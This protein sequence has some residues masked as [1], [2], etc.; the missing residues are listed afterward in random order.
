MFVCGNKEGRKRGPRI[1]ELLPRKKKEKQ[2]GGMQ[3]YGHSTQTKK[4]EK[5]G[6]DIILSE[7]DF[8][9][10]KKDHLP[11]AADKRQGRRTR[12]KF[13]HLLAIR[14]PKMGRLKKKAFF[15]WVSR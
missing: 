7:R 15:K 9:L 4:R 5:R 3:A 10:L 14:K 12:V 8:I 13:A 1:E 6:R 2:G 11:R